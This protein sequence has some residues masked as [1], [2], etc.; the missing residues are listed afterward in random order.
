MVSIGVLN[1]ALREYSCSSKYLPLA[2]NSEGHAKKGVLISR[3][4]CHKCDTDNPEQGERES[5]V[6]KLHTPSI[7][8]AY[9]NSNKIKHLQVVSS[10]KALSREPYE[11]S[12]HMITKQIT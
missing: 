5:Q 2:N 1:D 3:S 10:T 7:I 11:Q 12:T 4:L 8:V 6:F 9:R